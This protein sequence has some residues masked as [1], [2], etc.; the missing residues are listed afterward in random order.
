VGKY[1][2]KVLETFSDEDPFLS[3]NS[4][5]YKHQEVANIEEIKKESYQ[6]EEL[7]SFEQ[8]HTNW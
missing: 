2:L 8:F 1:V 7:Q 3:F 5:F 6:M 4:T